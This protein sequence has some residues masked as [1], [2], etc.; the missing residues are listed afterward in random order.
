MVDIV[1]RQHARQPK[2]LA[3]IEI[4]KDEVFTTG[5]EEFDKALGGG[6]RTGSVWEIVGQRYAIDCL[7]L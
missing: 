4:Q 5:D 2:C 1:S 7:T 6:I 3:D